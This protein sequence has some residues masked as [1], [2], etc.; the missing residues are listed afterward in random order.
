MP[1]TKMMQLLHSAV[2]NLMAFGFTKET[3]LKAC[4]VFGLKNLILLLATL[5]M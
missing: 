5:R 3:F 2:R 1:W 4:P